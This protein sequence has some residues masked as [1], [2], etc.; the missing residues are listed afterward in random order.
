MREFF[1]VDDIAAA[2]VFVMKLDKKVYDQYTEPM[3]SHI[4]AELGSIQIIEEL[5]ESIKSVVRYQGQ[6]NFYLSKLD[7]TPKKLMNSWR[8]EKMGW[9]A[10]VNLLD[11]LKVSYKNFLNQGR[12]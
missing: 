5:A 2:S 3:Q 9:K 12:E 7:V 6:I 10:N 11:G 1:Y 4:H 8:L